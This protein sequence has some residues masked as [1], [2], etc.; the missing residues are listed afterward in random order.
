MVDNR[1][2]SNSEE[3][4]GDKKCDDDDNCNQLEKHFPANNRCPFL[5]RQCFLSATIFLSW[6]QLVTSM[7][8]ECLQNLQILRADVVLTDEISFIS[9][10][11]GK[12]IRF[13]KFQIF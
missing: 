5:R 11:H 13:G 6:F 7:L 3:D 12:Q 4:G 1:S 10:T 9:F 2:L 8:F